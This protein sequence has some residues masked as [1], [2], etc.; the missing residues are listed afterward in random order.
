MISVTGNFCLAFKSKN[1]FSV[2]NP[3]TGISC[4]S[5]EFSINGEIESNS[6]K[7]SFGIGKART[8]NKYSLDAY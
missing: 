1:N 2:R 6:G 8:P 5:V 4:H 7:R 3:A